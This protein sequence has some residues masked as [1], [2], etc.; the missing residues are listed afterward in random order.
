MRKTMLLKELLPMIR[1][2]GYCHK[3]ESG[4]NI[5]LCPEGEEWTH[6]SFN[7][8]S[9]LL[10]ALGDLTVES[11]DAEDSDIRLWL[12]TDD[13]NWFKPKESES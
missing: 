9:G 2:S 10:D 6:V 12:K 1:L 4:S 13:Y 7:Q 3:D 8:N 5:I 11:I